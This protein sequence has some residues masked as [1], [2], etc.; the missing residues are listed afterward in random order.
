MLDRKLLRDLVSL[1]G[2][3]IS[4]AF[5]LAAGISV[6]VASISTYDSLLEGRDQFYGETRFPHIFATLKRAP[7][8]IVPA[9]QQIPGVA[10]VEP[11][12]VRDVIVDWPAA[13][14]PVTAR[15]VSLMHGGDETLAKLH[16]RIGTAP[17]HND[18][19][20]AA[21]NEAFAETNTV[22]L[23]SELRVLLNGRLQTFSIS[24]ISLS[25]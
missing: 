8:A 7:L 25:P 4:I 20:S 17:Q 3:V 1:R 22:P 9:L 23:G 2:Q 11:R 13:Q 12:I 18:T 6:F 15:I 24:G 21:I 19:R 14:L 10:V 16:L 5:V